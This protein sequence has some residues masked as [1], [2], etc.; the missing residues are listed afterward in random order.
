MARPNFFAQFEKSGK[1]K[2]P[3]GM[4]E[5]SKKDNA[6]DKKQMKFA[7][8]GKITPSEVTSSAVAKDF[9]ASKEPEAAY[10]KKAATKAGLSAPNGIPSIMKG[11]DTGLGVRAFAKGGAVSA[12]PIPGRT[13]AAA[14][15]KEGNGIAQRGKTRG[16]QIVQKK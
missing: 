5:G 14:F 13:I 1:D 11:K 4:K 10:N 3:K 15:R 12:A 2:D 9:K 8:G 7:A 16:T 6:M